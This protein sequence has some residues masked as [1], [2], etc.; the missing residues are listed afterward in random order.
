VHAARKG[1]GRIAIANADA[2]AYAYVQGAIDQATRAVAEL[3]PQARLPAYWRDPGPSP[4]G[5]KLT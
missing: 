1:W 3:L 2:G 5:L 4:R